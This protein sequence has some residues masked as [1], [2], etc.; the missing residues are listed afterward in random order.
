MIQVTVALPSGRNATLSLPESSKV[1]DLKALAR[2]SLGQ[3]LSYFVTENGRILGNP[4]E[5]LQAAKLQD[6]DWLTAIVKHPQLAATNRAFALCRSGGESVLAWGNPDH[7]GAVG[8]QL[9]NVQQI[10]ATATAFAAILEDG[11]VVT[12]G[13]RGDGGDSSAVQDQLRKVQQIQATDGAF[14]AILTD[15]SVVTWGHRGDG[16]DSSAVQDQL[17]NVQQIQ[18]TDK[19]FAAIL[20]DSSVVTWGAPEYGGDGF[21]VEGQLRSVR[22][23]QATGVAFAAIL[24]DGSVVTWGKPKFGGDSSAVQDR[25]K[26][27]QQIQASR[28]AFAAILGLARLWWWQL[29][30]PRSAEECAADSGHTWSL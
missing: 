26:R 22:Q 12:W 6:G 18:A 28:G 7:G 5:S 21:A 30:S 16:G 23:I 13:H 10:Q 11:S 14:A 20:E 17:R 19:A 15:G 24:E 25:L 3:S 1:G 9:R 27:V 8:P 2:E 29:C 4:V